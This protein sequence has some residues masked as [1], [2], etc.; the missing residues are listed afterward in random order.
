VLDYIS[1][2]PSQLA[3]AWK[4]LIQQKASQPP[5]PDPK[6]QLAQQKLQQDIKESQ[7]QDQLDQQQHQIDR[8]EMQQK[9]QT[10]YGAVIMQKRELELKER[11]LALKEREIASRERMALAGHAADLIHNHK[12]REHESAESALDR[13]QAKPNGAANG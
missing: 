11:E 10:T 9:Q 3:M 7:N 4:K 8:A 12:D 5:Q 2:L 6:T 13:K 1:G